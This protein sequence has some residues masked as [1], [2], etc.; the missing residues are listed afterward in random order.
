[1]SE[2]LDL[3]NSGKETWKSSRDSEEMNSTNSKNVFY[4][5]LFY[6]NRFVLVLVIARSHLRKVSDESTDLLKSL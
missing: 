3:Q 4:F 5:D 2:V 6:F 1:M